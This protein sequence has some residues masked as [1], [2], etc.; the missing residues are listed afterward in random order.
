MQVAVTELETCPF[1]AV[2]SVNH[3]LSKGFR[4]AGIEKVEDSS[5]RVDTKNCRL[6][7][8]E[9]DFILKRPL[10]TAV[11]CDGSIEISE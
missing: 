10:D 4:Y 9:I 7:I 8:V 1:L 2:S 3:Q 11:L 6:K 5:S